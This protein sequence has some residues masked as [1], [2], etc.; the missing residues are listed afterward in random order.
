MLNDW[1][2]ELKYI[3]QADAGDEQ[4]IAARRAEATEQLQRYKASAFFKNRTDVRYLALVFTG[5]K[6]Y[7]IEELE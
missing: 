3:K 7:C 2:V 1:V 5:K 4:L 6:S